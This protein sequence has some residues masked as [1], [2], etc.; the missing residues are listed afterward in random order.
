MNVA[1]LR[2]G[3]RGGGADCL[4]Q[5]AAVLHDA[6]AKG[7]DLGRE[8]EADDVG[9]IDFNKRANDAEGSEAKVLERATLVHGVEERVQEKRDVGWRGGGGGVR[10]SHTARAFDKLG[11]CVLMRGN[12]LQ[13]SK[14]VTDTIRCVCAKGRGCDKRVDGYNFLQKGCNDAD[15]VPED[16]RKVAIALS[17]LRELQ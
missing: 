9:V 15:R 3:D 6:E 10:I 12:A 8:E 5:F 13:K 7:D 11:S 16:G 4:R 2:V 14:S 1:T 17:L